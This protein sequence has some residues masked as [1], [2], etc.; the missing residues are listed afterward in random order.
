MVPWVSVWLLRVLSI[1]RHDMR[2]IFSKFSL[3]FFNH[4]KQSDCYYQVEAY[5]SDSDTLS[6]MS[7]GW[8]FIESINSHSIWIFYFTQMIDP[9][10]ALWSTALHV[11]IGKIDLKIASFNNRQLIGHNKTVDTDSG[12]Y[13]LYNECLSSCFPWFRLYALCCLERDQ[14]ALFAFWS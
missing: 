11:I 6:S 7:S 14:A 1:Y 10:I 2:M 12:W 3:K 5:Y 8:S 13:L 9:I 4:H